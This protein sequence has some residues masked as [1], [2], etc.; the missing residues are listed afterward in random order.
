MGGKD[1]LN[2]QLTIEKSIQELVP[3]LIKVALGRQETLSRV[4]SENEWKEMLKTAC[5]QGVSGFGFIALKKLEKQNQRSAD[6]VKQQ[7]LG[8]ATQ[9]AM[10]QEKIAAV[11]NRL[12]YQF[13]EAGIKVL[14]LKGRS[15]AKYYP[16]PILRSFGDLDIYSVSEQNRVDDLLRAI[17]KDFDGSYYRHSE[18]RVNGIEIENHRFVTDVRGQRRWEK[19]EGYLRSLAVARLAHEPTG[20]LYQPDEMFTML[21]F[22]YHAEIH[23]L[24]EQITVKFLAEW[25]L[26]LMNRKEASMVLLSENIE[27]YGLL[28]FATYLSA[29]CIRPLG[30]QETL[31]P[32]CVA[33]NLKR[34]KSELLE[35][36]VGDMFSTEYFKHTSD[37]LSDRV[38]RGLDLLGRRWKLEGVLNISVWQFVWEKFLRLSVNGLWIKLHPSTGDE[39]NP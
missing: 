18:C 28:P 10:N 27:K 38:K 16:E 12:S 3:E 31:L 32:E 24:Y 1:L 20:G 5:S 37:S 29:A 13:K 22:L 36:F 33:R 4:P 9:V 7:W 25:C 17:G 30:L 14:E 19:L 21:H 15:L 6:E 34:V 35:R 11:A 8:A 2:E 23:F 26:L 39:R